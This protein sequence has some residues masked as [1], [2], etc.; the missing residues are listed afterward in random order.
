[1]SDRMD[2]TSNLT[3]PLLFNTTNC[4]TVSFYCPEGKVWRISVLSSLMFFSLI[5]NV[6]FTAVFFK[7]SELRSAV[8]YFVANMAI[9]DLI[10]PVFVLPWRISEIYLNHVWIVGGPVGSFFCKLIPFLEQT[11]VN[12]SILSMVMIAVERFHSVVFPLKPPLIT[13]KK[14][15]RIIAP[16]WMFA[17][18]TCVHFFYAFKLEKLQP[19]NGDGCLRCHFLWNNQEDTMKVFIGQIVVY[20][21]LLSAV[22]YVLLVVLY[23]SIIYALFRQKGNNNLDS[24][25]RQQ[26][27]FE[28]RRVTCMVLTVLV[29][30]IIVWIP[31]YFR[32]VCFFFARELILKFSCSTNFI[33]NYLRYTFTIINPLVYFVFS[34]RYRSGLFKLFR[35]LQMTLFISKDARLL[36]LKTTDTSVRSVEA[37]ELAARSSTTSQTEKDEQSIP[38][39]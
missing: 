25:T 20:Y 35:C 30:F 31:H 4:F 27:L 39:E 32:I 1:M 28:N 3:A 6:L 22:P 36:N 37:Y 14:C 7:N 15:P 8:N 38:Q 23:S 26:R 21:I 2:E 9:S 13:V 19:P 34:E 12:V 29:A 33:M 11:S 17:I 16:L 5:G 24:K 10:Y 18:A